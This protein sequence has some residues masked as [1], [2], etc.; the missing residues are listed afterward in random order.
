MLR[1]VCFHNPTRYSHIGSLL[2][3]RCF[4]CLY[5]SVS[6][7]CLRLG[8]DNLAWTL[9]SVSNPLVPALRPGFQSNQ[10]GKEGYMRKK[11]KKEQH[12]ILFDESPDG[13]KERQ[14]YEKKLRRHKV[15][16]RILWIAVFL[17]VCGMGIGYFIYDVGRTFHSY[18]VQWEISLENSD[19][20]F[21]SWVDGTLQYS[22]NGVSCVNGKGEVVW[23]SAYHMS[24]PIAVIRGDYAMILDQ[25]GTTLVI[26]NRQLGVTGSGTTPYAITKGE[27]SGQGVAAVICENEEAS[28]IYY[29]KST[30]VRLDIEIKS[31]LERTGYP[32]DIALSED[33]KMLMVS[34]L[35]VDSGVMQNKVVFYNFDGDADEYLAGSFEYGATDT[36]IPEVMFIGNRQAVA[37]GDNVLTFYQINISGQQRIPEK[38]EEYSLERKILSVFE[39]E[40]SVGLVLASDSDHMHNTALVYDGSGT[41]KL[42]IEIEQ[43]YDEIFYN[44]RFLVLYDFYSCMMYDKNGTVKFQKSFV[45]GISKMQEGPGSKQFVIKTAGVL[46]QI[47]LR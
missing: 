1:T 42:N 38:K 2:T 18:A 25:K 34:Y 4:L 24:Q 16:T 22:Q 30:G 12:I 36:M 33:G 46:Q 9:R 21:R 47:Q 26:C 44:G 39:A 5:G 14:E 11:E 35:F 17:A 15:K 7:D 43:D 10:D 32:L 6:Q 23:S 13:I 3:Q 45:N 31:P 20:E 40:D 19:T 27:L 29:Y 41:Q 8:I 28:H 37:I